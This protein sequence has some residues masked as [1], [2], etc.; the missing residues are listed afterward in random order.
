MILGF[1]PF[2]FLNIGCPRWLFMRLQ[3]I[4]FKKANVLSGSRQRAWFFNHDSG[5]KARF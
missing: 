4:G 1:A 2:A 3:H 5:Q